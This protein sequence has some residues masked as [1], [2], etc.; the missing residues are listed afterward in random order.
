MAQPVTGG[1]A[2]IVALDGILDVYR[3]AEVR[4]KLHMASRQ[5][6]LVVDLSGVPVLCAAIVTELVRSYNERKAQG[7]EPARLVVGTSSVRQ[8]LEITGLAS[9]WPIYAN[10]ATACMP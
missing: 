2:F 1:N 10:V 5:R 9:V 6:R 7:L 4:R 8:V 3:T